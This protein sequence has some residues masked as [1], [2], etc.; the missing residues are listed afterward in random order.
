MEEQEEM[1]VFKSYL[2]NLLRA[3]INLRKAIETNDK[4]KSL[5]IINQLIEDTQKGIED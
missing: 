3:L 4:E 5:E 2:R 1:A